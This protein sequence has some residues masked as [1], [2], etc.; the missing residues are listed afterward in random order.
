MEWLISKVIS[1]PNMK[2]QNPC[3]IRPANNVLVQGEEIVQG[4]FRTS[5][6]RRKYSPGAEHN[7][8]Q[9]LYQCSLVHAPEYDD[10]P[11]TWPCPGKVQ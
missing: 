5:S 1:A 8:E 4:T 3:R 7:F 9:T 10:D 11:R 6:W 2:L